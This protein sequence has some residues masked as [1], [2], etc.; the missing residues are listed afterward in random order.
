MAPSLCIFKSSPATRF[1]SPSSSQFATEAAELG[2]VWAAEVSRISLK[3]GAS[4]TTLTCAIEIPTACRWVTPD[5]YLGGV[6]DG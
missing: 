1:A 3:V 6:D 5:K 4:L 2:G